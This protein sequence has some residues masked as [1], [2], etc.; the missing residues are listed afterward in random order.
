MPM[1]PDERERFG[2]LSE[3]VDN[4]KARLDSLDHRGFTRGQTWLVVL[5]GLA[6]AVIS[7]GLTALLTWML[8]P[9]RG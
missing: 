5:G 6:A 3:R 7:S 4:L 1:G 2:V 8:S 9:I